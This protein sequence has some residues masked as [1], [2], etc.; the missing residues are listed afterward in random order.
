MPIFLGI[1]YERGSSSRRS[2]VICLLIALGLGAWYVAGS[3]GGASTPGP[4]PATIGNVVNK[5]VPTAIASLPLQ[6][7]NG[8]TVTL[9]QF[10]GKDVLLAP[11][12][13]SCQEECPI[14][15]AA[16]LVMQR[17]IDKDGLSKKVVILEATV[18]PGRDT[19]ARMEAYAALA[20]S[21]W[22][23]L[24]GSPAAVASLWRQ[25]G[26]YY[27]KVAEASPPGI[28]WQSHQP[29]T[30]D[31]DHSDGFVLLDSNLRERFVAGGMTKIGSIPANLQ[32]LLDRQGKTNLQKPGAGTW[33]VTDGLNA[34]GW[35][36]GQSVPSA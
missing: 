23:L 4:P 34:I 27:Q 6:N 11:F 13:T 21:T 20:G 25:F 32:K 14:T 35:L 26:I 31:V 1:A 17:A 3:V 10:K 36:L 12:L 29:Y 18:D 28:D 9:D 5:A 22:P 24:T 16:L 30:Y 33:T 15:T 8:Q 7:Q 19:P 2:A